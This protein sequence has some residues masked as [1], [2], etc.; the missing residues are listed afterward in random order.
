MPKKKSPGAPTGSKPDRKPTR[1]VGEREQAY[2]TDKSPG[3]TPGRKL[4]SD[5]GTGG[6]INQTVPESRRPKPKDDEPKD[7]EEEE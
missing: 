6:K 7:G 4:R 1:K 3:P 5:K 2:S